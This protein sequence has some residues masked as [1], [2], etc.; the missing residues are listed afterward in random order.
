VAA[1]KFESELSD[2]SITVQPFDLFTFTEP[3]DYLCYV[4][5]VHKLYHQNERQECDFLNRKGVY[6]EVGK[7]TEVYNG[8]WLNDKAKQN[9]YFFV[10]DNTEWPECLKVDP[11]GEPEKLPNPSKNARVAVT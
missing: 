6:N 11:W 10:I 2:G 8:T 4:E 3:D 5:A 9:E 1:I 7:F